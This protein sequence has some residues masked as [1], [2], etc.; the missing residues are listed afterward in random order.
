MFETIKNNNIYEKTGKEKISA[1][2]EFAISPEGQNKIVNFVENLKSSLG[3]K[4]GWIDTCT[5]AEEEYYLNPIN[6]KTVL[7]IREQFDPYVSQMPPGHDKGHFSRDLL[8]SIVLYD[9]LKDKVTYKSE[10]VAG[11]FAGSF[12]D[13]GTSI[14]PRYQDNKYGAGHGE[15]GAYLFWQI[16]QGVLGEN[17]RKLISYSIA[18]HTHYLKPIEVTLPAGYKK[19]TYWDETWLDENNKL[20]GVAPQITRRADRSDTNG[21]TLLF[22]HIIS[23]MDSI[24]EGGQ[25]LSGEDWVDLNHEALLQTLN[26]ILRDPIKNPPTCI[27]HIFRFAKSN[28]GK[29]PYSQKDYLFPAFQEFLDLKLSQLDTFISKTTNPDYFIAESSENNKFVHDLFCQISQSDTK[30]FEKAWDNFKNIWQELSPESK[31]SWYNGFN[32]SK[33][34]YDQI[35]SFYQDKTKKSDFP[36]IAQKTIDSL[37]LTIDQK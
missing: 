24:Q 35:L 37:R 14:I 25:D 7:S 26:P 17:T 30:K 3:N 1:L 2:R 36:N 21:V 28:D 34:A 15:T 8:T 9:D 11:F 23:R 27:E 12:H 33:L 20:I 22:R 10:V 16:S 4:E 29:T 32:Y 19:D 5:K 18:A 31:S 6:E 13:I